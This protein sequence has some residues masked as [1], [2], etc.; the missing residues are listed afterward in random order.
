MT[1]FWGPSSFL[2]RTSCMALL[3][4]RHSATCLVLT[5]N[6]ASWFLTSWL[7]HLSCPERCS[8]SYFALRLERGNGVP[9]VGSCF[10]SRGWRNRKAVLVRQLPTRWT[11][12][13]ARWKR[14]LHDMP[15]FLPCGLFQAWLVFLQLILRCP[16]WLVDT[17]HVSQHASHPVQ[18]YIIGHFLPILSCHA[19]AMSA[20]MDLGFHPWNEALSLWLS[21]VSVS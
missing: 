1:L 9:W 18:W 15:S 4:F 11:L 12:K 2:I 13:M 19:S 5:A 14:Y 10:P 20:L 7:C 8:D 17:Q 6:T 21:S 3:I 16:S